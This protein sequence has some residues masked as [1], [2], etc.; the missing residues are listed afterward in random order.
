MQ[1]RPERGSKQVSKTLAY[2]RVSTD[3]QDTKNQKLEILEYARKNDF[4]IDR[5]IEVEISSRKGYRQ[6]QLDVLLEELRPGDRLVISELSRL[7]RSVGQ[8]IQIMDELVKAKISLVSIKDGIR[9]DGKGGKPD[10]QT[11]VLTTIIGL[12][13]EIERDLLSDRVKTGLAKARAEGK[14]LGRPKGT[15]GKSRLDP[16]REQIEEYLALGVSKASLCKILK[17]DRTTF[18]SWA[19]SRGVIKRG[20]K[21]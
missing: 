5:F 10:I 7:A 13:A 11:K 18:Y 9:L 1:Q 12:F 20:E 21:G 8:I 2:L 19:W 17:V 16:H 15:L 4:K 6:R 3:K 14:T